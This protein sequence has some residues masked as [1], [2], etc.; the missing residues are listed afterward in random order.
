[1]GVDQAKAKFV[2][3]VSDEL[4]IGSLQELIDAAAEAVPVPSPTG[5]ARKAQIAAALATTN[6]DEL[7]ALQEKLEGVIDR[8]LANTIDTDDEGP[9]TDDEL[10]GLMLEAL[11]QADVK[12]LLEI[13]Y[14]MM[15][16][17]VFAHI[18][19]V[20]AANGVDDPEH[21]P[22]EAVVPLLGK[23][24]VRQ[25]GKPKATLDHQKL[26]DALG[27]ERA[28]QVLRTVEIP[29]RTETHLNEDALLD[30]VREDPSVLELIRTC[31]VSDG[32]G[33]V[34]FH[35]RDLEKK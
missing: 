5:V 33:V 6:L 9:L 15:R 11:E 8:I 24:F 13:R 17:R 26:I 34:S 29:A 20:H 18:T 21:T 4:E 14:Q 2:Y 25:G 3:K 23:R 10:Y 22:G 12:R 1:M 27:P 19:A 7:I 16:T 31:V 30:L 28:E 35:I 32:Y